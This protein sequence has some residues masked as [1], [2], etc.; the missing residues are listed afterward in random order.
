MDTLV[1]TLAE[2]A[3]II[4]VS[5]E[6]MSRMA[7]EGEIPAY[8]DGRNWKIPKSLLSAYVENKAISEAKERRKL[9]EE[10]QNKGI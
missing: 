1:V 7:E 8:R 9:H 2:A 10:T 4:R 5:I 6:E 3:K